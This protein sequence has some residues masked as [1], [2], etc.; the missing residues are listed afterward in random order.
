MHKQVAVK[1]AS[2]TTKIESKKN[3]NKQT[4]TR[5]HSHTHK[6]TNI[7]CNAPLK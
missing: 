6:P 1:E 4:T 5:T 7:L 2:T 3:T